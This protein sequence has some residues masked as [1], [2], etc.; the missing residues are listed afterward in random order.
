LADS[1]RSWNVSPPRF[2]LSVV[3]DQPEPGGRLSDRRR[4]LKL[5]DLGVGG[6]DHAGVPVDD[7]QVEIDLDWSDEREAT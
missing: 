3:A 1:S 2:A 7:D 4:D 5:L 6:R